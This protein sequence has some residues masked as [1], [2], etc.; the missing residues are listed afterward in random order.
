MVMR[1]TPGL[2]LNAFWDLGADGWNTGMDANLRIL[3]AVAGAR[4]QSRTSNLPGSPSV[5]SI[6]I[7]PVG[8]A[9]NPN[10]IAIWDG[11][12]GARQWVYLTPEAGWHF[13]VSD[14]GTNVQWT[15]TSWVEF[16][17][18]GGG[19]GGSVGGAQ[20]L[21]RLA[22]STGQVINTTTE[23]LVFG[24]VI[25]DGEEFF[26]AADNTI[27]IPEVQQGRTAI[28]VANT[29]HTTDGTGAV[30]TTLER[31]ED[32]GATWQTVAASSDAEDYFGV[33]TLTALVSFIGGEWYRLRHTTSSNKTTTGD[34]QTSLSVTTI[35]A[36]QVGRIIRNTSNRNVPN[37]TFQSGDFGAWTAET[38]DGTLKIYIPP[39]REPDHVLHPEGYAYIGLTSDLGGPWYF[40]QIIDVPS[41]P[42][43]VSVYW[44][45]HT[46]LVDDKMRME[47]DYLDASGA[48]IGLFVGGDRINTAVQLW[49]RMGD[50]ASNA[51]QGTTKVR[52]RIRA[53]EVGGS[54]Q[55]NATNVRVV[56]TT[57]GVSGM[58]P[59]SIYAYLP[60][61]AGNQ[62]KVLR[63]NAT[64]DDVEWGG[65]PIRFRA[66]ALDEQEVTD[67]QFLGTAF[68]AVKSGDT[69]QL[70]FTGGLA[71]HGSSG[72]V[73]GGVTKLT[74]TGS[75]ASITSPVPGEIEIAVPGPGESVPAATAIEEIDGI[76]AVR[77]NLSSDQ[78]GQPLV[79]DQAA[80]AF[81]PL[82][83][84]FS[85]IA[86]GGGVDVLWSGDLA[87]V[88]NVIL[89]DVS[90][91]LYQYDELHFVLRNANDHADIAVSTDGGSTWATVFWAYSGDGA[92]NE[93]TTS[94]DSFYLGGWESD[95]DLQIGYGVLRF[96]SEAGYPS[97][98]QMFGSGPGGSRERHVWGFSSAAEKHNAVIFQRGSAG[99]FTGGQL[100]I[101]GVKKTRQPVDLTA[102]ATGTGPG[103]VLAPD[104]EVLFQETLGLKFDQGSSVGR[105]RVEPAAFAPTTF[106][107]QDRAATEL[108][109]VTVPAGQT[110][111]S[112]NLPSPVVVNDT[113]RVVAPG[114]SDDNVTDVF[115][116]LRGEAAR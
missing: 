16:A 38:L 26:N 21:L 29:R 28:F 64:G 95:Q 4:V 5:G 83:A 41:D 10:K 58:I 88:R 99:N 114:V 61:I 56:T 103:G 31:S 32:A 33:T 30:E 50:S 71:L 75:G 57:L 60:G 87:G 15:G 112:I 106:S 40:E 81:I 74:F 101:M 97:T 98:F 115:I 69:I 27:R 113:L 47:L 52:V 105:I 116:A 2:G 111:V 110:E 7:V 3:S 107:F 20:V 109:T 34:L 79:W 24:N 104:Q 48:Q 55:L 102:R 46:R 90:H 108:F 17:G 43:S 23:T 36:G 39:D 100:Y 73:S 9:T 76:G 53:V 65:S 84:G 37:H 66:G 93:G 82:P 94:T 25:D 70:S 11:P 35:D 72:E 6:Y 45:Q 1:Q 89:T 12:D 86:Y 42:T 54:Q 59:G 62:N 22:Q 78:N 68:N 51:P 80:N 85:P 96:F 14:E 77:S 92:T 91:N 19:G 49:E 44:D 67:L 8:D 13:Y 18:A 63:V